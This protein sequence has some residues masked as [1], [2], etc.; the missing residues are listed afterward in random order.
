MLKPRRFVVVALSAAGV[1]VLTQALAFFRQLL[2][3]AYFGVSRDLDIYV[4]AYTV[5]MMFVFSFAIT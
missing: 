5:A 4:I 3:A 2:V 1:T